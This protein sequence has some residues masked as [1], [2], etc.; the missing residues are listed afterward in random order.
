MVLFG[1]VSKSEV[2]EKKFN[3]SLEE[4]LWYT[5]NYNLRPS[6]QMLFLSSAKPDEFLNFRYGMTPSGSIHE[7]IIF[8]APV[9]KGSH[10][11]N[12]PTIKKDIILNKDF[13]KQIREQRGI[14]PVDYLIVQNTEGKPFLLYMKD[15]QRPF[16]I[17]CLWDCWK[18]DILDNLTY[19][20]SVITV[21]TFGEFT[22]V[23]ITQVPLILYENSYRKWLKTNASLSG[24]THL[25][26]P[27]DEKQMNAFPIADKILTCT[28]NDKGLITQTGELVDLNV[29]QEAGYLG[30]SHRKHKESG[31]KLTLGERTEIS[32]ETTSLIGK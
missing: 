7:K 2:I 3:V 16:G 20:F 13:R 30:H 4:K 10:Q 27:M 29:K 19:G 18:K 28:D 17:A 25:L 22:K 31:G 1:L 15:K 6:D 9:E 11:L 24:I 12:D 14:L 26:H 8:E 5:P 32:S 21:P 23:G